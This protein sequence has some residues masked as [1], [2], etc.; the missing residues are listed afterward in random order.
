MRDRYR[1][2]LYG[3]GRT[4]SRREVSRGERN[5]IAVSWTTLRPIL[6]CPLGRLIERGEASPGRSSSTRFMSK[7][8]PKV[9]KKFRT[10]S[11]EGR[12]LVPHLVREWNSSSNCVSPR[13]SRRTR[14][15]ND[16]CN[17]H[18]EKCYLKIFNTK[19]K[20]LRYKSWRVYFDKLI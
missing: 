3:N 12:P 19:L 9:A 13:N 1:R 10:S 8:S 18:F 7:L 4:I 15:F 11:S 16:G 2:D 5:G 14:N 17:S 20:K 6:E